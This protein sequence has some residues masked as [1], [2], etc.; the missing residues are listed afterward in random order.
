MMDK[1]QVALQLFSVREDLERDFE[2]TLRQV[3]EMGYDGVEF[4]GLFGH[5]AQEIRALTARYGLSPI[6]AHVP[7][8]EI[9]ADIPG[10][11]DTYREIGCRYI[12]IPWLDEPRRPGNPGYDQLMKD[13]AVVAEACLERG[14][15]LLYH[16]HDFEFV[17]ID[18]EY[19][20]DRMYRNIPA[21]QT[22]LDTCWVNVG[23]EDPVEYIHKYSGRAPVVHL[24]D[25]YMPE[26]KPAYLYELIG[27][28]E[29]EEQKKK[30]ARSVFEF[31]PCGYGAQD[32]PAI[33]EASRQAGAV[34]V[35]V[36]QDRPS[37]DKSPMECAR[38]SREYLASI[39]V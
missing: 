3:H 19:A 9:L 16:N 23:G 14:I 28:D 24:K 5:S 25:F 7:I 2:G 31:R 8:D 1:L 26:E 38:M 12:A 21:L 10:C 36:E 15:T 20:L 29:D 17:Q 6:S 34:W 11:L 4:A 35:V 37:M 30:K 33:V 18:G 13:I 27:V 22:E 32:M 39:G